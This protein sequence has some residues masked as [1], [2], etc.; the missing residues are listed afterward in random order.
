MK[1]ASRRL[2]L[3]FASLALTANALSVAGEAAIRLKEGA[4][5]ETVA[6]S[7]V[8]CHSLDYIEMNAPVMPPA[9]WQAT[10]R[11]MIDRMGA[12]ISESDATVILQYLTASYTPKEN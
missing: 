1:C 7:C 4:G 11:K 3:V 8:L 5:R 9:R 10:L 12:P 6:T 2:G